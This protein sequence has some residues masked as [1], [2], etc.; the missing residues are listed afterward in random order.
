FKDVDV[1]LSWHPGAVNVASKRS[2]LA[3]SSAKFRFY[4]KPA[5][6]SAAP[7][8]GRSALDAALVMAHA[9]ELLREHVP[10]K[11]RIHYIFTKAG[12][13][14]NIVPDFAEVFLYARHP[15]MKALDGIWARILKTAEAGAL[16]TETRMEMEFVDSSYNTLP[17]DALSELVDKNLR[18]VGGVTYTREEMDFA[19]SLRKTFVNVPGEPLG[20]QEKI[21][22]PDEGPGAASTDAADVSWVVP[23]S[24]LT[25]ATYVP[26]TP[27][28][29]WQSAACAGMSIGRKGMVVAAKT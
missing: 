8:S 24:Q 17:N 25:A 22:V 1:V 9:V 16:A 18:R 19:E 14:P 7:D 4:G 6:A 5:H 11:T 10:E 23:M 29:S 26:G 3:I 2:S 15:E 28:H 27:G 20:S 13:A 21:L 12:S